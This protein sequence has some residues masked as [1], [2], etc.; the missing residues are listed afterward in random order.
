MIVA[1]KGCSPEVFPHKAVRSQRPAVW[2]AK[3]VVCLVAAALVVVVYQQ[4]LVLPARDDAA[5]E[6][7]TDGRTY[8]VAV[9]VAVRHS[10]GAEGG[11]QVRT[12]RRT[13]INKAYDPL[14]DGTHETIGETVKA[15]ESIASAVVRGVAE[16]LG[17]KGGNLAI[18]GSEDAAVVS[19]HEVDPVYM[20]GAP[21]CFVQQLGPPQ[22]WTGLGFVALLPRSATP[23][24]LHLDE[25]GEVGDSTWWEPA[26]LMQLLQ[27][28][29]EQ[30]MGFHY[31]VLKK[32]SEDLVAGTLQPKLAAAATAE[33][34]LLPSKL[35]S[36]DGRS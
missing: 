6:H 35:A 10:S 33:K 32:V 26:E 17:Y 24:Q 23:K 2:W 13:V 1:P 4:A 14:Y 31:P 18:L 30:F 28:Q 21:Y 19:T 9:T 27:S 20:I 22:P 3:A 11:Y 8:L 29:P 34:L 7:A 25:K 36:R 5:A 16:E 15:G 12:Q